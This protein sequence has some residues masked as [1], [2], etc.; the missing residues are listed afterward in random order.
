[1]LCTSCL[2][3]DYIL[4]QPC[5]FVFTIT[6]QDIPGQISITF[7]TWTSDAGDPYMGVTAHFIDSPK[8][9]PQEWSL[10]SRLLGYAEIEG[11]H[12]GANEAAVLM[13]VVDRY[14]I[15]DKVSLL[16]PSPFDSILILVYCYF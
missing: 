13:R 11:N 7:D 1:M 15:R 14:D 3:H 10:E 9:R 5:T 6:L 2:L 12:S 4:I 8:E 16:V